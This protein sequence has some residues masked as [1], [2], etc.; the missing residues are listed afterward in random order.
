LENENEEIKK[1]AQVGD[2]EKTRKEVYLVKLQVQERDEDFASSKK[3][4]HQ[5]KRKH[6]E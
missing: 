4:F 5:R 1:R 3:K 6:H 2:H